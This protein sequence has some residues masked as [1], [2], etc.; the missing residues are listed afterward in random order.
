MTAPSSLRHLAVA[1]GRSVVIRRKH[2]SDALDDYQWR[3][4]PELARFDSR[5]PLTLS[6]S[7]FYERFERDRLYEDPARGSF[8]IDSPEGEHIGNVM[9]YNAD[10]ARETAEFGI[11]LGREALRGAGLGT[12]ATVAFLR[13]LWQNLPFRRIYLH[14]LDWNHRAE[15]CFLRA[16]FEPAARV[17]RQDQWFIRMEARREWWLMWDA[18]GRFDASPPANARPLPPVVPAEPRTDPR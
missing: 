12:D 3:R 11:S 7:D 6:F 5:E 2:P 4:D 8:S 18:E 1:T 15:R 13:Y 14:T 10:E 17:F 16:G 9:Y